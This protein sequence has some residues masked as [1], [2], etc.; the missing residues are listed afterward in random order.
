ME[1]IE[2]KTKSKQYPVHI[3]EGA[4]SKLGHLI[5]ESVP[6][7]S[8]ILI[9]TD[10]NVAPLYLQQVK[11]E[12]KDYQ[13][14][15][16]VIPAGESS[17]SLREYEK[18]ITYALRCQLD[19]NALIIAL[20]GGVVGDLAG[21]IASSYLRGIRFI[22][23]PTTLLAHD[24]SV[25]GKVGINH[26]LGKNLIGAFHQP[27]AV[28]FDTNFLTTLPAR[29][30]RSGFAEIVKLGLIR[31][32]EFYEFLSSNIESLPVK[33]ELLGK[34]IKRAIELKAE[35]VGMDEREAGIRAYLN[36]GHTLGH[37]IEAESRYQSISH[38]EAVMIGMLYAI[39]LSEASMKRK[40][41]TKRFYQWIEQL[42]Y[43]F[44]HP[45]LNKSG[46]LLERMKQD[47]KNSRQQ[48]HMVLLK[49]CGEATLEKVEDQF[50][51]DQLSSFKAWVRGNVTN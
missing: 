34:V 9:I 44:W 16:W 47:K 37:A 38:G 3:G 11:M 2:V 1:T 12:L 29:E 43:A 7:C 13:V 18:G 35:I 36:L 19:R 33:E 6:R 48:I 41:V 27:E 14:Y 4:I 50:I 46:L 39:K 21:F 51:L 49:E 40:I 24:S 42:G 22:Q 5:E 10:S 8:S 30:W 32:A 26:S 15:K 25:G 45:T 23:I 28:L 17:K 20:G 31:D